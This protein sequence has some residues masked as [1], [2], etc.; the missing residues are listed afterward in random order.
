M[1][2]RLSSLPKKDRD[3]IQRF[4]FETHA[5]LFP[6]TGDF[7]LEE[8]LRCRRMIESTANAGDRRGFLVRDEKDCVSF[9]LG[10]VSNVLRN[11]A[12]KAR[13]TDG[14]VDRFVM[15]G[16]LRSRLL[17]CADLFDGPARFGGDCSHVRGLIWSLAFQDWS[18]VEA[19]M[20]LR[21]PPFSYGHITT[22]GWADCLFA[23]VSGIDAEPVTASFAARKLGKRDQAIA[24]ALA[25]IAAGSRANFRASLEVV[26]KTHRRTSDAHGLNSYLPVEAYALASLARRERGSDL[27]SEIGPS[28]GIWDQEFASFD[29]R[30]EPEF[31][32]LASFSPILASMAKQ[33]PLQCS[34]ALV[35]DLKN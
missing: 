32:L 19:Y 15:L 1:T 27:V 3:F 14:D 11:A 34:D 23:I 10:N 2:D 7:C 8:R 29:G 12:L 25:A 13:L 24:E 18:A 5:D 21:R 20:E 26:I 28:K 31:D 33:L 17:Y 9:A 30:C 16:T 35:H 6:D 22:R 4:V